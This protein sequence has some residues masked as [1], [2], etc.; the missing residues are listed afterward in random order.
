MGAAANLCDIHLDEGE[1]LI[2]CRTDLREFYYSFKVGDER[3]LRNSLLIG[4]MPSDLVGFRCY[5]PSWEAEGR[6]IVLGLRT[7]AMGDSMAVELAQTAHL[8]ILVQLGLLDE[9]NL[10][11]MG[12]PPRGSFFGGVVIDDLILFEKVARS[13]LS[14]G[15]SFES[16]GKMSAA[17]QRYKDLGLLPHEGKTFYG[18]LE[19]EFWGAALDG[20]KGIV[21]ANLKRVIPV[22]YA[23]LGVLKL[24]IC[25]VSLLEVLIGC[26]TSIFL[27]KRRL[28]SLL[29]V[30]YDALQRQ[31]DRRAVLRLSA[32]LKDELL[33]VISLAPLAAT[34]LSARDS[35]YLY[36]S[37]ASTWGIAVCRARLPR[38][39]QGEIHRH[40]LREQVWSK[41]LSPSR[42]LQRVKGLLPAAEELPG[43][44]TLASHPFYIELGTCLQ[45]EELE[46]RAAFREV[47]I[48]I[49]ELRGLV[50]SERFAAYEH[51]PGRSFSLSDS[52]V[53]LGA[54]L[55]G[56]C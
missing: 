12:P 34:Y 13:S 30:C 46:R 26:W 3:L 22:L 49:L 41:L 37:D 47:H 43:D 20:S 55:K 24:G 29:N 28:L 7:L 51:F 25:T 11:A 42:S 9:S 19:S 23:T 45:F 38:W 16:S 17:L 44:Q 36:E 5:D 27:F 6:P 18:Q 48:N 53:A 14:S 39:L 2:T 4:V 31:E 33:L 54:W 56:R 40:R 21:R 52:Q 50:R 35:A 8:G 15:A 32:S 10:L 1:A